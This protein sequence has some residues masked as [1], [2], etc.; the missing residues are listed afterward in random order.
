MSHTNKKE[1]VNIFTASNGYEEIY[2]K[3]YNPAGMLALD[4]INLKQVDLT[5]P[6]MTS[7]SLSFSNIETMLDFTMNKIYSIITSEILSYP[8]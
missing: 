7:R 8:I 6:K 2:I 4:H 3:D 5:K 1:K